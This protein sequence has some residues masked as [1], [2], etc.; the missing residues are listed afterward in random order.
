MA[1]GPGPKSQATRE[2]LL[3]VARE[4]F[5]ERGLEGARVD[6]IAARAGANKQLL[7][8]YFTS[9]EGLYTAVL[10]SVYSAVRQREAALDLDALPAE[11]AM[12][13]LVEFSFDYLA[14][15]PEFVALLSDENRHGGRHLE[16]SDTLEKLNRPIVEIIGRTLQRGIEDGVFRRGLDPLHT[17]LSIAGLCFF[18][19]SNAQTLRR[20]FGR[21][22]LSEAARRERRAHIVDFVLNALRATPHRS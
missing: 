7:Y 15:T 22:V 10:E 19:F 14:E 5:A 20:S 1:R 16:S 18:Y 3:A 11:E 6:D 8:H 17:Y 4:V 9:K 2:R 21:D 12:R 13:A